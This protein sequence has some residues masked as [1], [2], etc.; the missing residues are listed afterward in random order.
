MDL[1][2][3]QQDDGEPNLSLAAGE[4]AK[5]IRRRSGADIGVGII[6]DKAAA[7][8]TVTDG[9]ETDAGSYNYPTSRDREYMSTI[10][11]NRAYDMMRR[12][13]GGN[14]EA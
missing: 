12:F 8:F 7:Y 10:A 4:M 11:V 5:T 3:S 2:A 9:T 13:A 6:R 1:G 14:T